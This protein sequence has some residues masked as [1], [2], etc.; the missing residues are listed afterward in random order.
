MHACSWYWGFEVLGCRTL[1]LESQSSAGLSMQPY[2]R[3]LGH[4]WPGHL[5]GKGL[6]QC[7][8]Y[9]QWAFCC[10]V[11]LLFGSGLRGN[12][13]NPGWGLGCVCLDLGF[14][15]TPPI[16]AGVLGCVR[17]CARSAP[18]PPFLAGASGACVRAWMY[19]ANCGSCVSC[20]FGF[21]LHPRNPGWGVGV[22][23]FVC[24]LRLYSDDPGWCVRCGCLCLVLG[25]GC[26]PLFLAGVLG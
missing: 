1:R 23:V 3:S 26:A 10:C 4:V 22:C 2:H 19:P 14:A 5:H 11:V 9:G 16:L 17:S 18:T 7:P 8:G 12:P 24:P 15:C 13:A 21:W 6:P 20:G 25:F